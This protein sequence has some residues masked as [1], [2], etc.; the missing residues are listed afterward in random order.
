M[1]LVANSVYVNV[2]CLLEHCKVKGWE[3]GGS[4]LVQWC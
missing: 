3:T 4:W 1:S 2:G